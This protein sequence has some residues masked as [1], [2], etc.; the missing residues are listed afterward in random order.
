LNKKEKVFVCPLDWGLGH[1][2][3]CIPLISEFL[4]HDC[5]VYIGGKGNS[6]LILKEAFPDLKFINLP[7]F[8]IKYAEKPFFFLFLIMQAPF[9]LFSILKEHHLL[10]KIQDKEKFDII[11]SD[12][13]YGLSNPNCQ[14]VFI[15]HQVHINLPKG[16]KIFQKAA[17]RLIRY[18]INKF[19]ECWV[20]DFPSDKNLAGVLSHH[21]ENATNLRYVGILSRFSIPFQKEKIP[22][23]YDVVAIVSGPEPHRTRFE[24][25]L[26]NQLRQFKG[27]SLLIRGLPGD[28]NFVV[29]GNFSKVNHL[30]AAKLAGII[31]NANYVICRSG[32][33]SVMDM[34]ALKRKAL[35]V[36][37]PGQTEQEYI[38]E[39]LKER[40]LFPCMDQNI[41]DLN[42]ALSIL[43]NFS[44][45][46]SDYQFPASLRDE[47]GR[48][49]VGVITRAK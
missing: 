47:I 5:E 12:N 21:F 43:E 46:Y 38:A 23:I 9:F 20:P 15:T 26:E 1:A 2:T 18:A 27:N 31:Q 7:G 11:I 8:R 49:I 4:N 17:N 14:T 22:I 33:S 16:L 25:V 48:L 34:V 41:F 39:Y 35:L 37:T 29:N 24:I 10:R 19:D 13:R 42:M 6:I 45:D 3:R 40:G 44:A 28:L 30:S 32:Y 36:P